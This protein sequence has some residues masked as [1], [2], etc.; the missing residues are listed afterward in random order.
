[1]APSAQSGHDDS[2]QEALPLSDTGKGRES[3]SPEPYKNMV[4]VA[5]R[6]EGQRDRGG[7]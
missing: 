1:M 4:E 2:L 5:G 6:R 3:R 7:A